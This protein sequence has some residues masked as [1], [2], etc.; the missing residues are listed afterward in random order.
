MGALTVSLKSYGAGALFLL[1]AAAAAV[2]PVIAH[3]S[4][5]YAA[6]SSAF[7]G[8]PTQYEGRPLTPLPMSAREDRFAQDF[9]GKIGRFSDGAREIIIRWVAE[10][11]RNLHPASDC[12]RGIGY[13]IAPLP[14]KRDT[15]GKAM[16]CFRASRKG[17]SMTV[18]EGVTSAT[19]RTWPDVSS[20]YWAALLGAPS[21]PWWS[22]VVAQGD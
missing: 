3:D 15:S 20:W 2:A 12:F 14:L 8:W 13:S 11:T 22:V 7:P 21:G 18:C 9:P 10:P 17:A 5:R 19:G 16:S 1:A 4:T 6:Q